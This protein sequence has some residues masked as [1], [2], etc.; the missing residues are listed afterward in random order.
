MSFILRYDRATNLLGLDSGIA[1]VSPVIVTVGSVVDRVTV[2]VSHEWLHNK[3]AMYQLER[4]KNHHKEIFFF[5]CK[6]NWLIMIK[7]LNYW[8]KAFVLVLGS[9]SGPFRFADEFDALN[10]PHLSM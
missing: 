1:A 7:R 6:R 3:E 9:F 8:K 5:Y 4:Q 10:F 2:V